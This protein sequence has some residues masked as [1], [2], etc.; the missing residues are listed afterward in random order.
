M[1][2]SQLFGQQPTFRGADFGI[3]EVAFFGHFQFRNAVAT[4]D[5]WDSHDGVELVFVRNGEGCWEYPDGRLLRVSGGNGILFPPGRPHRIVNGV[6]PPCQ[7]IWMVF[8]PLALAR[9]NNRL[10]SEDEITAL[11]DLAD[12]RTAPVKLSQPLMRDL[13]SLCTQLSDENLLIG[14]PMLLADVRSKFYSTVVE[15]WKVSSSE[16]SGGGVSPIVSAAESLLRDEID[17][18]EDISTI[19]ARLG[20]RKSHLYETFKKEIGMSPNDYRQR[21]RIKKS[22]YYLART[23]EQVTEVAMRMGYSSSQYFSRVFKKYI[24]FTPKTYRRLFRGGV[25]A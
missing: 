20:C 17:I 23:D 12:R 8:Q 14:S 18:E 4:S 16:R 10:I 6:Y 13:A 9:A 15:F 2:G 1:H 7:V 22:C 21:L 24:G 25:E 5:D 19:S 3:P 11:C